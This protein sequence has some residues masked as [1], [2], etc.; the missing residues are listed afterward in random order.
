MV[1]ELPL[2]CRW[3]QLPVSNDFN[4]PISSIGD[5]TPQDWPAVRISFG[6][7]KIPL[8]GRMEESYTP[9]VT[10]HSSSTSTSS[11][12]KKR[13]KKNKPSWATKNKSSVANTMKN[14][15]TAICMANL[16]RTTANHHA[17]WSPL[18]PSP[19]SMNS[20]VSSGWLGELLPVKPISIVSAIPERPKIPGETMAISLSSSL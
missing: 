16:L 8:A 10:S 18:T 9:D 17:A 4:S 15:P 6:A 3:S 14:K 11:T 7:S 13:G 5:T 12:S 2:T 1:F 19:L 20:S